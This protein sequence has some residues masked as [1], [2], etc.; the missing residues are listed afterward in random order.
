MKI[1]A[2][3]G[4][5]LRSVEIRDAEFILSLRLNT[6]LN[7]HLSPVT[8]ILQDQ[9]SF[10]EQYREKSKNGTE[11]Y[12]IVECNN[13]AVGSVRVYDINFCDKTF[14]WGSWVIHRG[15]PGF[16]ALTSAY[17]SYRFAFDYLHLQKAIFD[18]RQV[19]SSVKNLYKTYANIVDEDN[20][21]CYFEL[22]KNNLYIFEEK[23]KKKIPN[24]IIYQQ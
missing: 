2:D 13:N 8:G 1:N 24:N 3:N 21:N 14:T 6:D 23:F 10:L 18:V 19:N 12:F 22:K 20:L 17:M 7:K 4:V 9:I 11:Y 16:V 15:Y 5:T